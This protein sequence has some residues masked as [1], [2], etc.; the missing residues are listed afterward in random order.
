VLRDRTVDA[1]NELY[2]Q[3]VNLLTDQGKET[4]KKKIRGFLNEIVPK[5]AVEEIYFHNLVIQ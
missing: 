4:A 2:A 3:K 5:S 1:L